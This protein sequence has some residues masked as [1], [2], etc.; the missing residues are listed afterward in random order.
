M[1]YNKRRIFDVNVKSIDCYVLWSN[2]YSTGNDLERMLA[3]KVHK[4]ERIQK[5][6]IPDAIIRQIQS[7]V[8]RGVFKPGDQLPSEREL[9]KM[10]GVSRVP[11]REAL[12]AL[13]FVGVIE[14]NRGL[15]YS[16]KGIGKAELL[17][18]LDRIAD[19][20]SDILDDLKEFRIALETQAVILACQRHDEDDLRMMNE[21]IEH[22]SRSVAKESPDSNNVIEGSIDFHSAIMRASKNELFGS[23]YNY[24]TDIIKAGRKRSMDVPE[25]Y[26]R[27]VNDHKKI[28]EAIKERNSD[29]AV[30]IMTQHLSDIY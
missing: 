6:N 17:E 18:H 14:L 20:R 7:L 27:A 4:F 19:K 24:I 13:E 12:K 29:K 11:I 16:I 23:F 9:S 5:E 2:Q 25:R 22:L 10:F 8:K 1:I 15:S 26:H 3:L 21:A 30:D 28:Y